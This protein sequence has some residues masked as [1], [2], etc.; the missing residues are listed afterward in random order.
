MEPFRVDSVELDTLLMDFQE[1]NPVDE[2]EIIP[3]HLGNEGLPYK[4][5]IIQ[6]PNYVFP[7]LNFDAYLFTSDNVNYYNTRKPLTYLEYINGGGKDVKTQFIKAYHTQNVNPFLNLGFR[8]NVI[9]ALGD[10]S[11]QESKDNSFGFWSSYQKDQYSLF[12][13][14][15]FNKFKLFENGGFANDSS[16]D[17]NTFTETRYIE[18]VLTSAKSTNRLMEASLS[19]GLALGGWDDRADSIKKE[20]F[21]QKIKIWHNFKYSR[22]SRAFEDGESDSTSYQNIFYDST[23][24]YDSAYYHTLYNSL[25][26]RFVPG[27]NLSSGISAGVF[28][29]AEAYS[30][31]TNNPTESSYGLVGSWTGFNSKRINWMIDGKLYLAGYYGGDYSADALFRLVL[32]KD[33]LAPEIRFGGTITRKTPSH[34][35]SGYLANH[36]IWDRTMNPVYYEHLTGELWWPKFQLKLNAKTG[37]FTDF[38]YFDQ[39]AAPAQL[40]NSTPFFQFKVDKDI[41]FWNI[42][43]KNTLLYQKSGD[44]EVFAV[45]ELS[46]KTTFLIEGFLFAKALFSQIGFELKYQTAYYA[47]SYMPATGIFFTQTEKKIGNYPFAN[48]F[49]NL[50]IKQVRLFFKYQHLNEGWLGNNYYSSPHYPNK[51]GHF[52]FGLSWFFTN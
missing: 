48:V 52:Y 45:P 17:N 40:S 24:T 20:S 23:A 26:L 36:Y 4:S 10:Y 28:H 41:R 15:N 19:H 3:T 51:P 25:S 42:Q 49:L 2:V 35:Y 30:N 39:Q 44:E 37:L 7:F 22:Y 6:Q 13:N 8:V 31:Y 1:F 16:F 32:T 14:I 46:Y 50:K 9:H 21:F 18:T 27:R 43:F 11:R 38:V 47:N 12:A 29:Q 34:F 5:N 33:S